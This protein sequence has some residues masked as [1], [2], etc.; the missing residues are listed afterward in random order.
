MEKFLAKS[1]KGQSQTRN[2]ERNGKES[3]PLFHGADF[4]KSLAQ[5]VDK[6]PDKEER[7]DRAVNRAHKHRRVGLRCCCFRNGRRG[8]SLFPQDLADGVNDRSDNENGNDKD[9]RVREPVE[10]IC[11]G[12]D[13]EVSLRDGSQY[14][15]YEQRR[16][17]PIELDHE[18]T[19]RAENQH[20]DHVAEA[21]FYGESA[22]VNEQEKERNK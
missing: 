1:P 20:H 8:L 6:K 17:L 15:A 22:E 9:S 18:P 12:G 7:E 11:P 2:A 5:H 13:P 21:I 16:P 4:K 14:Q 10:S 3:G 19:E